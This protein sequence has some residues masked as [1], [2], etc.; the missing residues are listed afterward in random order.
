[1]DEHR[2]AAGYVDRT[3]KG[4]RTA[5]TISSCRQWPGFDGS[6]GPADGLNAGLI[7]ADTSQQPLLTTPHA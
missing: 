1:L 4:E 3:L 7:N 2:R 5:R 6:S